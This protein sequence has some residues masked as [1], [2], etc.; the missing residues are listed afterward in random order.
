MP[1]VTAVDTSGAGD[2][3]LGA[4]AFYLACM[5]SLPLR[6]AVERACAIASMS[7]LKPGTQSSYPPRTDIPEALFSL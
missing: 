5:P 3:F 7:V 4:L 1:P 6:V 2:C